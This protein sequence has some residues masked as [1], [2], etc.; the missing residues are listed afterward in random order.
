MTGQVSSV[1]CA[2][3]FDFQQPLACSKQLLLIQ[4]SLGFKR[5]NDNHDRYFHTY[6]IAQIS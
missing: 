3:A 2:L 6:S 1:F 4:V 5:N